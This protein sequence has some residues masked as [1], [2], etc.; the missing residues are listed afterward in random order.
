MP[1]SHHDGDAPSIGIAM[2]FVSYAQNSED[3][4]LWRCFQDIERGFYVDVGA[5]FADE[6]SVTRA[7]YDRG[8]HGINIEAAP[9]LAA[10]IARA[11]P[12]DVT[13]AVAAGAVEGTAALHVVD[14]SGLSTTD[15]A[16]ASMLSMHGF[17]P[18]TETVPV[19]PLRSILAEH[20]RDDIQFLKIDVEGAERAALEGCDF[21]AFRPRVILIE[22]TLPLSATPGHHEWEPI[23]L[24]AGYRF[25]IFD[26]LNRFYVAD[27]WWDA[28][29]RHFQT[30]V[31]V[32]DNYVR[33][34][35]AAWARRAAQQERQ[36]AYAAERARVAERSAEAAY[37]RAIETARASTDDRVRRIV[38][39][40]NRDEANRKRI[41]ADAWGRACDTKA[42]EALQRAEAAEAQIGALD[43]AAR[44]AASDAAAMRAWLQ[45]THHSTSW[46]LTWPLRAV[47]SRLRPGRRLTVPAAPEPPPPVVPF[48]RTEEAGPAVLQALPAASP[49]EPPLAAVH[50]RRIA[51]HQFHSGS[52]TGDAVTNSML[53]IRTQLRQLGYRSDIFVH[54]RDPALADE[55]RTLDEL[56]MQAHHVLIVHHSMGHDALAQ[57]LA[58]PAPKLLYYHNVTPPEFLPDVESIRRYAALGREQLTLLRDCVTA[59]LT[60]SGFS[61]LELHRLGFGRV[62][63][64]NLLF[65]LEAMRSRAGAGRDPAIARPFTVL[66]VGRV[67]QSKAQAD[68]IDAFAVFRTRLGR[69]ARLVL[70]G[71]TDSPGDYLDVIAGRIAAHDL[72]DGVVLTGPVADAELAA[73]YASADLYVSMSLH[74]GFGV[75]LVEAMVLGLP[76]LAWPSGAVPYV[77]GPSGLLHDRAPA[78]VAQ[79]MLTMAAETGARQAL[80]DEQQ[81]ALARHALARQWPTMQAA[82]IEAGAAAP[83]DPAAREALAPMLHFAITGHVHGSYSLAAVNR[84][85]AA[86]VEEIRPGRVRLIPPG[87]LPAD[88][89]SDL[90]YSAQALINRAAP[91]TGPEIVISQHYPILLPEHRGD[92]TL[93]MTFWEESLLPASMV[94]TL[95]TFDGVLAPSRFV[96]KALADSGVSRPIRTVGHAPDLARFETLARQRTSGQRTNGASDTARPFVFLHVSSCFPRKG[97]DVLLRA[98]ARA[99]RA[100]DPVRLVI[101]GFPNPHN[102][103]AQQIAT[104]RATDPDLPPVELID[105]DL[106][107]LSVLDLYARADAMVLP[108]RGEGF[109][110]PAAEAMASGLPL[111]VTGMGGHLDFCDE[112]TA[113]LVRYR[114]KSG[115]SHLSSTGSMWAEPDLDDLA[116]ALREAVADPDSAR[117]RASRARIQIRQRL[118][119]R[120]FVE[121]L[122]AVALDLLVR[123]PRPPVRILWVTSWT[124]RCGVAEY[125]R[126]L[127]EALPP[128]PDMAEHVILADDRFA[129]EQSGGIA[130]R[131]A[132][133]FGEAGSMGQLI[134]AIS[135][136][137]PDVAVIQ[138]QA[139]LIPWAGLAELL[140]APALAGRP[141]MVTLHHTRDLPELDQALRSDVLTAL[142]RVS[143]II[144]HTRAD[145]E[146][147]AALGLADTVLHVPH[148]VIAR[149]ARRDSEPG[150]APIIGCYGF[151]LPGKGIAELIRAIRILRRSRPGARLRLVNAEYDVPVSAAEIAR[152]RA[153]ADAAGLEH[154]IEWHTEFLPEA[155]SLALLSGCDVIV[156]PTQSSME[157]SSAAVRTALAAG[158]PVIVTPLPL[159]DDVGGAVMRIGGTRPED[160]ADGIG[161]LLSGGATRVALQL[162]AVRWMDAHAWP[163][164]AARVQ[165]I[166]LGLTATEP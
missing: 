81:A 28:L 36:A 166:I 91:P 43:T 100:G 138:H 135:A 115:G 107:E 80:L 13:L 120:H 134:S 159:F 66:F 37:A 26:G 57:V 129:G 41:E 102:D 160:I 93:A 126:H 5:A 77:A 2:P 52:A 71:R 63:M 21:Q 145:V 139:G 164:I 97:V 152:C 46:R 119:R 19:R 101:K 65:D 133:R 165:G 20:G 33:V 67:I 75:P 76:V 58:S 155:S 124:V 3:V 6:D 130:S 1:D 109:N 49:R 12:R 110:L 17:A 29:G 83:P 15:Q 7:F 54:I 70:V 48:R 73:Q 62:L 136:E 30:P 14:D 118:S 92:L 141:V 86:A 137:D 18:R 88:A 111:I 108:S 68:L 47:M 55:L 123:P 79:R 128:S 140:S 121:R 149:L 144:V 38:A 150:E 122:E 112:G 69:P 22:A 163:S 114:L 106:G 85:M 51:V 113:R 151:F 154:V 64:S 42:A 53:L 90:S 157:A 27:E 4:I 50:P 156:I 32:L 105:R 131:V 143:R 35:D 72:G 117:A 39:E 132:W 162:E 104:L 148:G 59:A 87:P 23:V 25:G 8:W 147:L 125:S 74:E 127:L 99:F 45:A 82:L 11:R 153:E 116:A 60:P 44:A 34:S 158:P 10:A 161:A 142:S 89:A 56:P 94:A 146:R 16:N 61:G 84:G 78:A 9:R 24:D 96:A 103:V 31:N 95:N 40:Q 98:Y